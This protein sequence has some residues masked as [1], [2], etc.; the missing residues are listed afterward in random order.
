MA[1]IAGS[2]APGKLLALTAAAYTQP[3]SAS[4]GFAHVLWSVVCRNRKTAILGGTSLGVTIMAFLPWYLWSKDRWAA[5]MGPDAFHF[6]ASMKTPL[7]LFRELAGAGYWGS[8]LLVMLCTVA[9]AGRSFA[10]RTRVLLVLLIAVPLVSVFASDA[11][12]GYFLAARQFFWVLPAVAVLAAGF[13][14]RTHAGFVLLALLSAVSMRQSIRF[15][16]APHENWQA[17]GDAIHEKVRS[18]AC[19][20]VA[21]PEQA[22]LYEFFQPLL[23]SCPL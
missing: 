21:P 7:M 16:T 14:R 13:Q 6:A 19:L 12:F 17:A 20:V 9:I 4:V 1:V 8:G 2:D 23:V 10:H 15:F 3:Y 5:G 11:V 22:Y 18:G